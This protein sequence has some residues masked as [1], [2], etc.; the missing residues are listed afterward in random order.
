MSNKN[1]CIFLVRHGQTDYNVQKRNQGELPI[2]LN[3]EGI[4]QAK[5]DADVFRKLKLTAVYSSPVLR[6]KQTAEYIAAPHKVMTKVDNLLTECN[7]GVYEG[8]TLKEMLAKNPNLSTEQKL[9]G[10]DWRPSKGETVREVT[11]RVMQSFENIIK[12]HK[13]ED[14]I[15][16]VSHGLPLRCLVHWLHGGKPEDIWHTGMQDNAEIVEVHW[17]GEKANIVGSEG[18]IFINPNE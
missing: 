5:K 1:L 3:E 6:A 15:V 18:R 16:I 8:L 4:L 7:R 10:I 11:E 2:P 14:I 17:N 12:Q 9:D 13:P